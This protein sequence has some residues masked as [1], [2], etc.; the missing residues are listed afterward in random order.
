[1]KNKLNK[2]TLLKFAAISAY[3]FT[4]LAHATTAAHINSNVAVKTHELQIVEEIKSGFANMLAEIGF[5]EVKH[6]VKKSLQHNTTEQQAT[7]L[8]N[9]ATEQLPEYKFK[10]VIA[11]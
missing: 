3:L 8:V 10:V 1:M 2:I 9:A 7:E 4:Q 5:P 6:Q 11:D